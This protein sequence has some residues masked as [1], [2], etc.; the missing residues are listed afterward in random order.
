MSTSEAIFKKC[1]KQEGGV[2]ILVEGG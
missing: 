2:E 1:G